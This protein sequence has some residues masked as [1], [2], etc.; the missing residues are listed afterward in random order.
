MDIKKIEKIYSTYG[1]ETKKDHDDLAVFLYKKSNKTRSSLN[2][3]A[4]AD[5]NRCR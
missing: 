3:G 4:Y 2:R 1:F 5:E